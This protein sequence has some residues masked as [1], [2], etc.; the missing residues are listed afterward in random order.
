MRNDQPQRSR[1][2]RDQP[3]KSS[4]YSKRAPSPCLSTDDSTII[5]QKSKMSYDF[6][7]D[8]T[9]SQANSVDWKYKQ[10]PIKNAVMMLNEMFPPPSVII[11][12]L[13]K[14]FATADCDVTLCRMF[15]NKI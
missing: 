11:V 13:L 9:S 6:D 8:E 5:T 4:G 7:D 10:I 3:K 2:R 1:N 12:V 14:V 15:V